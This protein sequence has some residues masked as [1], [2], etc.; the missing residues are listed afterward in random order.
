M[1]LTITGLKV[2]GAGEGSR[3]G[4]IIGHTSS[5]K[6]IYSSNKGP[7]MPKEHHA[8]LKKVAMEG[9]GKFSNP[10]KLHDLAEHFSRAHIPLDVGKLKKAAEGMMGNKSHWHFGGI[11]HMAKQVR[12][13]LND[14]QSSNVGGETSAQRIERGIKS[15]MVSGR[16]HRD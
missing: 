4:H 13:K 16:R 3:G 6:P 1:D 15:G 5:G 8:E 9:T 10:D 7:A 14:M 11:D 2:D 12:G